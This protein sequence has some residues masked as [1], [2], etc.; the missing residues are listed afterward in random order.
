MVVL[1][2]YATHTEG[3]LHMQLVILEYQQNCLAIYGPVVR[4]FVHVRYV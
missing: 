1:L 4:T 3:I 2:R